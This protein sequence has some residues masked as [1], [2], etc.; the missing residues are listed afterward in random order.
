[1]PQQ[2]N[3][4]PAAAH[5]PGVATERGGFQDVRPNP[6][7]EAAANRPQKQSD[8]QVVVAAEGP[9]RVL[10]GF[11]YTF[12]EDSYGRHWVL[13]EGDNLVGRADTAVK[14]D[15]P[16][17]HGTTSTRHA[18]IRCADGQLGVQDLRSTN[19]TFV[20]GRRIEPNMSTPLQD[21]DTLRFGAYTVHVVAAAQRG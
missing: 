8:D 21:G 12:Q 4:E 7:N 19:G 14:C 15:V 11:V 16:I 5:R 18:T 20:K 17:A 3:M 13:H 6:A 2:A 1:M 9:R 10:A